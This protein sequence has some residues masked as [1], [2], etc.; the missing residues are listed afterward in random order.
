M[1]PTR[2]SVIVPV[3]ND[4]ARLGLLL[5]ALAKQTLPPE[6]WELLVV[7]NGST[8]HPNEVLAPFAL[9][10]LL[11]ESQPGSY[12]ARNRAL[13]E[14]K[15]EILAFT[16]AD[17]LPEPDWLAQ[18]VNYLDAHP[19]VDA[20]GGAIRVFAQD[21]K[22]PSLAE[23]YEMAVAFPQRDYVQRLHYGA[24]ANMVTRR[25]CFDQIG[26]F[27]AGLK[28]GGDEN[29]GQ[30]LYAAGG[31]I[32]F[33]ET[34]VVRHPARTWDEMKTKICRVA[35]GKADRLL[36]SKAGRL[37]LLGKMLWLALW[38]GRPLALV[39]QLSGRPGWFQLAIFAQ[40]RAWYEAAQYP[41][42]LLSSRKQEVHQRAE[43]P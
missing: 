13:T 12:A 6:Q 25:R 18:A 41:Q 32:V 10:R 24:T 37:H 8:D 36:R 31:Q 34:A 16:D 30:R 29:W 23:A 4:A 5:K 43:K 35:K 11:H 1:S 9:A 7:D 2:I 26:P 21:P 42:Y 15:G 3:F 33:L 40:Q 39:S 19:Q 14:A 20:I 28:S 17:C 27:D 22:R 38:P